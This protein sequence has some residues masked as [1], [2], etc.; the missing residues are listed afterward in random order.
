MIK[1][2]R[3]YNQEFTKEMFERGQDPIPWPT[4]MKLSLILSKFLYGD[5]VK[6]RLFLDTWSAYIYQ[7]KGLNGNS[8][9]YQGK[10]G[11]NGG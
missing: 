11:H 6:I 10:S 9:G 1:I 7:K 4:H 8:G 2:D 5:K 3:F